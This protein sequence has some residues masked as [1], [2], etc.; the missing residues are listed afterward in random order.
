V[1][2]IKYSRKGETRRSRR[3]EW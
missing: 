3:D 2:D 1:T